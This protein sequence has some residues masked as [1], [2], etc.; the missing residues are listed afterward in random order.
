ME[1]LEQVAKEKIISGNKL[2][3]QSCDYALGEILQEDK[4]GV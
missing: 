3:K 4:G 1:R 2:V